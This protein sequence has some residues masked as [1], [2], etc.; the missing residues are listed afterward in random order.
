LVR[1]RDRFIQSRLCRRVFSAIEIGPRRIQ[2]R[3]DQGGVLPD[4]ARIRD[5]MFGVDE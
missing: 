4:L 5:R 1:K 2:Q 3:V